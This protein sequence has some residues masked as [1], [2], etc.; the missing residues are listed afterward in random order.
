M[1]QDQ[2]TPPGVSL[3]QR[4]FQF[5]ASYGLAVVI[6][7]FLLILTLLGTLEQADYGLYVVQQKYFNALFLV[8][9][10]MGVVPIPLPG[11]YLLLILLFVNLVCGALLRNLQHRRSPG[12]IVAHCGILFLLVSGFATFRYAIHGSLRLYEGQASDEFES[13]NEWVVEIRR[14]EPTP[15][16]KIWVIPT[17]DLET[18]GPF[19]TRTFTSS[20]LPFDLTLYSHQI[21]CMPV[22]G[23]I[24]PAL[25]PVDGVSLLPRAREKEVEANIAGVYADLADKQGGVTRHC[26]LWGLERFPYVF[27]CG[28]ER[29]S[30]EMTRRKWRL[31]F[32]VRLDTFTVELYPN[33]TIPKVFRSDVTKF[34]GGAHESI[35]ISM[36]APLRTR[37][38]TLFQ[39][40][41]GPQD[42][43][44]GTPLFSGFAVVRN[45]ADQ[46]PLYACIIVGAGMLLHFLQKLFGYLK[47]RET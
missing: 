10:F 6:L 41:W 34:E 22:S 29:W 24:P 25:P 2:T 32:A 4:L 45:P 8:H 30:V 13:Y 36:N 17:D 16:D 33:T 15:S 9:E 47:R 23:G 18:I 19:G 26:V 46:W 11:V 31:P 40:T 28:G 1:T 14:L 37:G 43:P 39:A 12:M 5:L 27:Q 20:D 38:Y 21:N 42:A 44:P 35:P 7:S 3:P